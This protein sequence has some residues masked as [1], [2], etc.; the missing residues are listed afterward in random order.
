VHEL[1]QLFGGEEVSAFQ[2]AHSKARDNGEVL[3]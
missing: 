1:I 2:Y 3:A